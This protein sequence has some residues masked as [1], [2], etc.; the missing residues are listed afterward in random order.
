MQH[1]SLFLLVFYLKNYALHR[2]LVVFNQERENNELK[3]RQIDEIFSN[4]NLVKTLQLSHEA[5][6]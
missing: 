3:I 4:V 2:L 1:I 5:K 6:F